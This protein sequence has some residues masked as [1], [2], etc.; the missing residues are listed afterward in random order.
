MKQCQQVD[1]PHY[2]FVSHSRR[3][4]QSTSVYGADVIIVEG[5][6]A[7]YDKQVRDELDMKIFVD[8]DSDLR[9][10]RRLRRD[11]AERG[12]DVD[13][14]LLQYERFVKPAFDEFVQV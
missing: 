13:G 10:C 6:M 4:D 11:I 7:L 5:I 12:R 1:V 3:T 8:T 9:L 14:V 2:D